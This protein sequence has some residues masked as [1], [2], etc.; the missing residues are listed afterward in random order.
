ML[1]RDHTITVSQLRFVFFFHSER[2]F[3]KFLSVDDLPID[4]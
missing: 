4:Y 2:P 1:L 3:T